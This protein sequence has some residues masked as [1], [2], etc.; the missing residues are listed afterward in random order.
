MGKTI[1]IVAALDTKGIEAAFIR[2]IIARR[3]HTPLTIDVGVLDGPAYAAEV[4]RDEVARAGGDDIEALRTSGDK[5]R[6]MAAMTR[7]AAVVA[8]RLHAEGRIAGIIGLGGSAGT[9]IGT[10]AMR[11]LPIGVPKLVL[12][13]VA[14]G[15]TRPYVGTKDVTMM[16]SVVDV[17]GLNGIST[18]ILANA[19]GAIVGMVEGLAEAG[20][21]PQEAKPLLAA[22]M[23]GNT[24]TCVDRARGTLEGRGYEVLVFHATGAGGQTMESLIADG[25]IKGVFDITT[26][27]WADELTGGVFAAG[28]H[29][30][31]A[32]ARAGVPQVVAPGCLDMANFG[33]P[34]TV[35]EKYRGRK[36]YEWNP[37]VTLMR[38]NV[39]EN[40]ELGRILAE[41]V[42]LSSAP[43]TVFLP[44]RGVSQLDSPGGEFW[45][46][47]ADRALYDAIK[48]HLRPDIPVVELDLNINDPAFADAATARLLEYLGEQPK[49]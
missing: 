38:T 35:P 22:S 7:G 48:R 11:A 27:E 21:A 14:A 6:A 15:D 24:T 5:A 31:E 26:T 37:T 20:I 28:P 4:G 32:A 18:P 43:V 49:A 16:Y 33:G 41:K 19:A 42:N 39:A 9:T 44:L 17:A 45:W 29:R 23:F 8:A 25:F 34:E 46:P 1:A 36:L 12:S 40:A 3:G 2:D 30:L 10:S 13:T 47:E